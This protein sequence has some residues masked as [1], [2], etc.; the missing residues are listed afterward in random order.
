MNDAHIESLLRQAPKPP[1]PPELKQRLISD[2]RLSHLS[3]TS[4]EAAKPATFWLRWT[5]A[6]S[7]GILF[8]G[9]LIVLGIQTSQ[10]LE[11]RRE[12]ESLRATTSELEPLRQDAVE[13]EQLRAAQREM[14]KRGKE[15]EELQRLTAETEELRSQISELPSL[16]AEN[17]RLRA[18]Y[19]AL[20][21][22]AGVPPANDP[23]AKTKEKANV[24][25]CVNNLKQ[26]GLAAR[27]WANDHNTNGL[28]LEWLTMKK[29][30]PTPKVLTC[31]GDT[32][33][34]PAI[35]W[36]QFD[37]S[38]V[39]YELPSATPDER[40]PYIVYSR[41]P[42]HGS[43]G[44][45]DGSVMSKFDPSR[46]QRVDSNLKFQNNATTRPRP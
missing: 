10:L 3:P 12:N 46:L 24:T 25:Q 21:S 7:F 22:Q 32:V 34:T 41:C 9:C 27:M 31:P 44:L 5:P 23:F 8:L 4:D 11:L 1:T 33:R 45:C 17:Q 15:G 42:I 2:I 16:R 26:I 43:I 6:L 29:M 18:E 40:E 38:S 28:P 35:S 36:D 19:D 39:S 13:L 20:A 30:L 37:G 14:E